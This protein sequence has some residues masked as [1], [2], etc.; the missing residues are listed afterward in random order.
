MIFQ[1]QGFTNDIRKTQQ[2]LKQIIKSWHW[3]QFNFLISR[4]VDDKSLLT[5]GTVFPYVAKIVLLLSEVIKTTNKNKFYIISS[6][7]NS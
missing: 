3:T 4:E 1:L 5:L 6:L 2:F 7:K